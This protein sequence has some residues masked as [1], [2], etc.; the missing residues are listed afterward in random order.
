MLQSYMD[1]LICYARVSQDWSDMLQRAEENCQA[2]IAMKINKINW[3]NP[4]EWTYQEK[5]IE[6]FWN[7]FHFEDLNNKYQFKQEE[8]TRERKHEH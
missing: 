7:K 2:E 3:Q 5:K 1:V 6:H 4:L 8:I